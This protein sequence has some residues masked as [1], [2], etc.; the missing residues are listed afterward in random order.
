MLRYLP[1]DDYYYMI[2]LEALPLVRYAPYIYR[3]K[4]FMTWEIGLHNPVLWI[5]EEDHMIKEG[6]VFSEEDQQKIKTYLN[7]NNCDLDICECD[8]KTWIVYAT[9]DQLGDG[10]GCMAVYDGTMEQFLQ[11]FFNVL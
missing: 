9:G 4:D 11:N 5:S 8:G 1:S 2:C 7:I 10:Y 6:S 3:T